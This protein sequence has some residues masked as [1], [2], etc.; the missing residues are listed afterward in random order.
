VIKE[1]VAQLRKDKF[2]HAKFINTLSVLEFAGARKI[3]KSQRAEDLD[4]EILSHISEE[5]RHARVLKNIALKM[6]EGKLVTYK[7]EHLLAGVAAWDYIQTVDHSIEEEFEKPQPWLNYLYTTLLIEE[8]AMEVYP[9]YAEVLREF[10]YEKSLQG[11]IAEEEN[12]LNFTRKHILEEDPKSKERLAKFKIIEA[13][14]FE[15]FSTSVR[16]E[17]SVLNN[18][19]TS[20]DNTCAQNI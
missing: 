2:L 5:I 7:K 14:A 20:Q 17:L 4:S 19:N 10:G 11:M 12:H 8:R 18:K 15:K 13:K 9:F 1:V 3:I 16:S 6:S